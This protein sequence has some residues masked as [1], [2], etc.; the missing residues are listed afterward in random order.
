MAHPL[1]LYREKMDLTLEE[2]GRL[3]GASRSQV[4]K[5]EQGAVPRKKLAE[6]IFQITEGKLT[7]TDFVMHATEAA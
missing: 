4:F 1:T 7:P 6:K 3:V 2:F 5:W